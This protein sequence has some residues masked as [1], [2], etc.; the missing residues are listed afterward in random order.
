LSFPAKTQAASVSSVPSK[1]S[2]KLLHIFSWG[3]QLM[4]SVMHCK[5][6]GWQSL[7]AVVFSAADA[8]ATDNDTMIK[9]VNK[10]RKGTQQLICIFNN[11]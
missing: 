10:S 9:A 4:H 11:Y 6:G 1:Q 5:L 7:P 2:L 3:M 8:T